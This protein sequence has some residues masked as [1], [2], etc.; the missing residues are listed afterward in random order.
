[1]TV[2][3]QVSAIS[4]KTFYPIVAQF[5]FEDKDKKQTGITVSQSGIPTLRVN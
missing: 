3:I 1:L 4:A 5:E 2:G